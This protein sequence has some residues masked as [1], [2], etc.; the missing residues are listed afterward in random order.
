MA[1]LVQDAHTPTLDELLDRGCRRS[2]RRSCWSGVR[3]G[4]RARRT[5]HAVIVVD[6]SIVVTALADDGDDGDR[7]RRRLRVERL[8]APHVIDLGVA[9]AWSRL[10]VAGGMDERRVELALTD[11]LAL[12]LER[13]GHGRLLGRCWELRANLTTY[14]ATYVAL[15][16][17]L[18]TALLTADRRLAEAPGALC[19]V[20][21]L[22]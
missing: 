16:E 22:S 11:L 10:A 1:R 4:G 20:E 19:A 9:S 2:C 8:V 6:A 18:D 12:R 21:V 17:A 15:A 7:I 13:V 5:R 14:D 3:R